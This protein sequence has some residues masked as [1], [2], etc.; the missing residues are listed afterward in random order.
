[1][2]SRPPEPRGAVAP[3]T[4]GTPG[5][6]G[7]RTDRAL[8]RILLAGLLLAVLLMVIGAVL[9]AAGVN[10]P[11]SRQSVL[12][13]LPHAL[14]SLEPWGF[15]ILGLLVLLAT[16]IARV[17]ALLVAFAWHRSWRFCGI[18]LVVLAILALSI[19]LGLRG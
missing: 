8:S 2:K 3:G 18:C 5:A 1:M 12:A 7:V 11:V 10:G 13:D 17:A 6:T 15:F 4:T 14:A 16:P 19:Y 9:A